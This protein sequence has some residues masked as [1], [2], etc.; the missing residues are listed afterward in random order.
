M[1]VYGVLFY[2]IGLSWE[3]Y[4]ELIRPWW[5]DTKTTVICTQ[6]LVFCEGISLIQVLLYYD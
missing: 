2:V 1:S 3:I 5:F 4:L 6:I